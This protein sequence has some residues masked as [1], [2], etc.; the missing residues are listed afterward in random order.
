MV[1]LLTGV[2][3]SKANTQAE[4]HFHEFHSS[5]IFAV[6]NQKPTMAVH[7]LYKWSSASAAVLWPVESGGVCP[8]LVRNEIRDWLS[9]ISP[10]YEA[11]SGYLPPRR[12]YCHESSRISSS[13]QPFSLFFV[14]LVPWLHQPWGNIWINDEPNKILITARVLARRLHL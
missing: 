13:H 7:V 9:C 3:G 6:Y 2:G 4:I 12:T 5:F 8:R 1:P 14:A 10:V 11:M